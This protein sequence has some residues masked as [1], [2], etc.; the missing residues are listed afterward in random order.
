MFESILGHKEQ[1]VILQESLNKNM[2]SHAYLF[3]GQ[4]GIGKATMAKEFAKN[5]LGTENLETCPDYTHISKKEDKKDI[6]IEQIRKELID[7]IYEAPISGDKKVY[8][9]DDAEF[10]NLASQN[11]LLKTL[12]EP[13]HYVVVILISSN[14]S[15]FLTTIISRVNKISFGKIEDEAIKTYM[16][17]HYQ[18]ALSDRI[19]KYV[20]GS[21]GL[22]ID[23]MD[24]NKI[25]MIEKIEQL[26]LALSK[27]DVINTILLYKEIDFTMNGMLD[28]LE[29]VLFDRSMFSCTKFVEKAKIRLKNNGNYDIVIDNMILK[30]IENIM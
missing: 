5:I 18:V 1:K 26:Y 12:E 10:L 24:E 28:Y 11:A 7:D 3:F 16:N 8:L 20:D 17:N 19:L 25:N 2:I 29:F 30:I 4:K 15:S 9:I 23:M 22:A 14:L 6:I 21:L 27:K 13:P